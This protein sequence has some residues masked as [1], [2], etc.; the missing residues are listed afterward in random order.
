MLYFDVVIR[1]KEEQK[2]QRM[3]T[4]IVGEHTAMRNQIE[5]EC[6]ELDKVEL[7]G[8]FDNA[9]EA[10]EFAREH[11]VE[12]ALMNIGLPGMNG[13]E[14]G[15]RLKEINREMILIYMTRYSEYVVDTM[16]MKADYCV[17][18]PC[19]TADIRD[20]LTRALLLSERFHKR[21]QVVTFGR[22]EV[23]VDDVQLHFG[24]GKA[25]ELLAYCIHREGAAVSMPEAVD[26]LWPDRPYDEKVKRLYRKATGYI[27]T[28][29]EE[30]GQKDV[31]VCNRGS[32]YIQSKTVDCDLYFFLE[33]NMSFAQMHKA[34]GEGYLPEY[35]WA[36]PKVQLLHDRLKDIQV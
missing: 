26:I 33:G 13:I 6:R 10:L 4:I 29:L 1:A 5:Q 32:C 20:A 11:T 15:R 27:Q 36:E 17:M 9:E 8:V 35:S 22:F 28:V 7:T 14:L 30:N 25:K 2:K 23:Y 21:M 16:R 34:L 19:G 24:N 12:F 31:F 18:K 3:K